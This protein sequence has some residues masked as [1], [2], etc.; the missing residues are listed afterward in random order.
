MILLQGLL[1]LILSIVA[2]LLM[3]AFV[4]LAGIATVKLANYIDSRPSLS[5][6]LGV[7]NDKASNIFV[8]IILGLL[9]Y[10]LHMI[11]YQPLYDWLW[12]R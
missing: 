10:I 1:T 8:V 11:L 2:L 12:H 3:F 9:I 4:A 5:K 7:F 6:K